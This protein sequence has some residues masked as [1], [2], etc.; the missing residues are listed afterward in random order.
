MKYICLILSLFLS[1]PLSAQTKNVDTIVDSYVKNRNF[2]GCVLIAKNGKIDYLKY[3]G[4]ANR[5]YDIKFSEKTRFQIFS[6]TKTFT[7]VLIM[8]LYEQGKINLDSTI[9]AYYPEYRGEAGHKA[10]IKNLLTYSSG[11]DTR[12]MQTKF[13]PEAYDQNLWPV[14]TFI[15]KYCSEKLVDQPGTK[16]NY[17]NGDYII[18]GKIIEKICHKPF[19]EVLRDNILI[20]LKMQNT[21]YL[22]HEDIVQN[23]DEGYR[24]AANNP[25]SLITPTNHYM[26]NH[27]SAGAMYSTPQDLL[28]FD[29]AIFN[30]SLLK[31]E[32]VELMLTPYEQLGNVAYGFWVYPRKI[33]DYDTIFAERQGSGYAH[34]SNWV[35][36]IDKDVTL[37]LLSN[38]DS[39]EL[40]KMRLDVLAAYLKK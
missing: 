7:A 37:I 35:H 26:D 24:S 8:Q 9:S 34:E 29:Q 17:N 20:P 5:H 23:L 11:R 39:A 18:L 30:H 27:F 4:I 16:F 19:E 13:I 10:T 2:N 25:D 22:H 21:N 1:K 6:V 15:S 33:G 32:T 28:I 3:T 40:N 36:L 38:T 14:D 12:E 31:K